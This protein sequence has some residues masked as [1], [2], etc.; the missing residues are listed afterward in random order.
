MTLATMGIRAKHWVWDVDIRSLHG[1]RRFLI[2]SLRMGHALFRALMDDPLTLHA[3]SLVYT[4]L[5]SIVP[6]MAVSFSILKS[7]GVHHQAL[8]FL[9]QFLAPLGAQQSLDAARRIIVLVESIDVGLLGV[10]GLGTLI[11]TGLSLLYKIEHS[12]NAVWCVET[13]RRIGHRVTN[14]LS[15]VVIGPLFIGLSM[16]LTAYLL[17]EATTRGLLEV[18]P[19]GTLVLWATRLFPYLLVWASF[20]FIYAFVP[21]VPVTFRAAAIGG[22]VGGVLWQ[23]SGIAFGAFIATSAN[24]ARIYSSLSILILGLVWLYTSWLI[25]LLGA[26]I[27]YYVQNPRRYLLHP[28]VPIVLSNRLRE[29]L[30]LSTM[31]LIARNHHE[32][33]PAFTVSALADH[34]DLPAQIVQKMVHI[35]QQEEWIIETSSDPGGWLP[36]RDISTITI[37]ELIRSIRRSGERGMPPRSTEPIPAAVDRVMETSREAADAALGGM[38]IADL[39]RE[40]D[41][42]GDRSA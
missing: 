21:N 19:L 3:M 42:K 25:L 7:F 11:Y 6:L 13:P 35:L 33:R 30:A 32:H 20:T 14:Y 5:L 2:G 31:L 29:R 10:I 9:V 39:L 1:G 18:Q 16:G 17:D 34:L 28:P 22:L 27:A 26:Q 38:T 40:G 8:P 24:Y 12:I 15:V 23:T 36:S 41:G 37:H 4:T